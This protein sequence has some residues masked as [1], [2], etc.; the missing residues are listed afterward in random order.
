VSRRCSRPARALDVVGEHALDPIESCDQI[1]MSGWVGFRQH[2]RLDLLAG[3]G[4][5]ALDDEVGGR[6][7]G[8]RRH[9]AEA[10]VDG[11]C[12]E[13]YHACRYDDTA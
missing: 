6:S 7:Y 10:D 12:E 5:D 13:I 2:I 3:G 8:F 11:I 4:R 1:A 9:R